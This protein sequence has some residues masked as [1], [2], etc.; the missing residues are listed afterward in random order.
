VPAA[1]GAVVGEETPAVDVAVVLPGP[2][3]E[4]AFCALAPTEGVRGVDR[5]FLEA[6]PRVLRVPDPRWGLLRPGVSVARPG[7]R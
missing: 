4:D 5:I 3:V 1:A 2:D 7:E 6:I